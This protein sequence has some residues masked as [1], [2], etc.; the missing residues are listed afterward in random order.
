M[1]LNEET[2]EDCV[3]RV[4]EGLGGGE[5]EREREREEW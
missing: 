4:S 2:G 3:A 1:M 5:R